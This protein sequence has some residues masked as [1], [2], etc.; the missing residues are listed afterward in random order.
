M[1]VSNVPATAMYLEYLDLVKNRIKLVIKGINR[2]M[3]NR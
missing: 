2:R 3:S 1:S